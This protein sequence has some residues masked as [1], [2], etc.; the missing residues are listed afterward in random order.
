MISKNRLKYL[1]S[2]KVKKHRIKSNQILIEGLR[3][4]D[5]SIQSGASIELIYY[6]REFSANPNNKM[7]INLV[8]NK[9]IFV[10]EINNEGINELTDSISNQGIIALVN[11]D[12]A[13]TFNKLIYDDKI[14][15]I[16]EDYQL[17]LESIAD[18]G[19]LGNI[20][21]TADW[22]GMRSIYLSD[23]CTDPYNAK[24][25]RSAM[26]AHFYLNIIQINIINHIQYLK[27][28][29]F[30]IFGADIDG[31]SIYNVDI[32][33]KCAIILGNEAHGISDNLR[34]LIDYN[35]TIPKK[36]NI[37]SLNVSMAA[38]IIMSHINKI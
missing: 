21:R 15:L 10:E 12:V 19:N 27:E 2:L 30:I 20:L 13:G 38:G 17:I 22:F 4:I 32:P 24:V 6:T 7:F 29:D 3:L 11:M 35:I 25:I 37:E 5:E 26:G 36:G 14:K 1:K 18:P 33:K 28:N 9:N 16:N 31:D 34:K 23:D 8:N